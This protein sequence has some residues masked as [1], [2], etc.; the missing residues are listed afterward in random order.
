MS[1]SRTHLPLQHM[2]GA[3]RA[4]FTTGPVVRFTLNGQPTEVATAPEDSALDLLR[5]RCGL[6]SPKD[7][8][9]PQGQCGCCVVL[10]DGMPRVTCA[11]SADKCGG[12]TIVTLEGLPA[13]ERELWASSFVAAAGLQCGFCIPGIVMRAKS[14]VDRNPR[15]TRREIAKL[16]DVH[17]CRC[18]GYT[19]ILD[20]IEL[21]A[22][23]KR[24]ERTLP[25][26][27]GDGHVGKSLARYQGVELAMGDRPYTDDLKL[28]DM[29]EGAVL[30]S[31]H[32]RAKI[33]AIDTSEAEL[34]PGVI[35]VVT[36][37]DVPGQNR[38][39]LIYEDWPPFIGVGMTTS[40]VGDVLA[41]VAAVDEHTARAALK[42]IKVEYEVLTPIVDPEVSL[43]ADA[44][45]LNDAH[46]NLLGH[47]VIRRG[48]ADAALAASAH[49]VTGTWQTQRIE[50]LYLEP[51]SCVAYPIDR[52]AG[53]D[54]AP[55]VGVKL[56]TQGQG[57]FDDR[58]QVAKFLGLSEDDV[59]VELI[60]NG[61]A[62]GGKED[63]SIQAQT[64]LLAQVTGRPVKLALTRQESVNLHP[65]RH[66]IRMTYT[67]G[68]DASGTL[69]A[70]K[71]DMLGDS[72]A[73]ASVGAKVLERAAGHACGAYNVPHV[74]VEAKAAYTNNVP[75]GA[76]R[77]FG[78]NQAQFAMEG[79][80]DQ[81]A[82][83]LGMDGWEFRFK[84]ALEVGSVFAS[85][86]VFE[87]S[88][89]LKKT[90]HAIK[91][92]YDAAKAA[93]KA[94]GIACGIKNSGIGNGA[95]EWGKVRLV[96]D[97]PD[98]SGFITVSLYNGYTE[99]GQGLL[100]VLIQCAVEA[101][102][103]P[104]KHFRAKVD[105]TYQLGCG[106][107]TGS[108]ATLLGG[109]A[110]VAAGK[111]LKIDLDAGLAL[112]DLI[113]R[114]YIGDEIIDDTT[115]L[116]KEPRPG[117]KL[118]T[119]TAFGFATQLVIL[120]A[121]GR[122]EKV[123]AAHDVGRA[124]NPALCAGQVEGSVHMGLGYALTEEL[125]CDETGRPVTSSMREIGV[126]RAK[127]TP[128]I[129]VILV[130]E[131]EPEGPYGAKGVGEIG[132]VPTAPAVA[133]ALF[134]FDGIRRYTLPM[135][136]SPAARAIGVGKIKAKAKS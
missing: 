14:I 22:A 28:P 63:M 46:A 59:E 21:A 122:L 108:R 73:Y 31:E 130:E 100:T 109:R 101:T 110:A 56:F 52:P 94:C 35:A 92:H 27:E 65:K 93:G 54:G 64:A 95:L 25:P 61:G 71:A 29:L 75:C 13:E 20:A 79:A 90:L 113:G 136:D 16:L 45:R 102:G 72:G 84:N 41:A 67:V 17:L 112:N 32:A 107:T 119:H 116:G 36:A 23:V 9:S 74:Y 118:K 58:R 106:Q 83:K 105:S 4:P 132:L 126:L 53:D 60:P 55:R 123:Y 127:D 40:M 77:G 85:G 91:P 7:G 43:R 98:A 80:M 6:I 12:K 5:D 62:F 68:C 88:V 134:A 125:P 133:G 15:P 96:V 69:T 26:L 8:C 57:I 2:H 121:E 19:K 78:A 120:D 99:M 97:P 70:V 128:D 115:A 39:G 11:M 86:Q 51:E 103:I 10:V 42:R 124:I 50:H 18:T 117:L 87:K 34:L 30:C 44:P 47:S 1:A 48:D 104:A 131:H 129:E 81:L 37:K 49:V 33:L 135:K 89:G 24:G 111:K 3:T 76:F 114:V 66:P 38:V 82:E